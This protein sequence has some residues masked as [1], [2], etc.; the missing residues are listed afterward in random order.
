MVDEKHVYKEY[1]SLPIPTYEEATSS[2]PPSSQSRLGPEEVSDD[3]ERQGLLGRDSSGTHPRR[4]D[5]YHPPTVQSVRSSV[6]SDL[7][8][9]EVTPPSDDEDE[10]EDEALRRDMEE[11]EVLDPEDSETAAQRRARLRRTFS[12]R[13]SSITMTLSSIHFP[14]F[15]S[16]R[17]PF[18]SI[19]FDIISSRLP[20]I[21]DEYRPGWSVLARL[22]GLFVL[23]S[24]IYALLVVEIMPSQYGGLGQ[25]FNSEWVRGFAQS[26]IDLGRI[27]DNLKHIS[28]F[29]H[30]AGSEGSLYLARWIEGLFKDGHMDVY[31]LEDYAVYLNYP[32]EGGRRVAII[33]PPE[34]AWEAKIEEESVYINPTPQQKQTMVF[35]GHSKSGNVK[36]PLI[37]ANY[38]SRE[39]FKL[40]KDHGINVT[41]SV[42]LVRYYGTQG[43]RALKVK[44][45]ELA[46]AIGCIIYSDPEQDGF[47]KGDVWPTGRW[48]P[49]DSVQ[50]GAVS[51]MSWVIGDVLTPGWASRGDVERLSKENN[52]GLVNIP[53]IPLAWRD[54]Q[55]LLSVL[56]GHGEEVPIEWV[57]GIPD[58]DEFWSGDQ[59]SPIVQLK[60]EQDEIEKQPI[61]NVLG[62]IE[63]LETKAKK[64]V[65]GNHRDSWCFGAADP[66]SGTAVMLEVVAILGLLREQGWRPLRTIEFAS[67]DAEEYNL[68]GS[69]EHVEENIEDLRA[70]GVAYLNVDVGV[71]GNK[72]RA[73][74]SPIFKRALLR[75]LDRVGD[76]FK[77]KTLKTIWEESDSR[78]EGLGAGSDYVA[79]QSM[80]GTSSIDFGFDGPGYPYHSCY[81]TFEWMETFGD[82]GFIYHGT[83]AEVWILLILELSQEPIIPFDL[84]TYA[85]AV[86]GYINDMEQYANSKGAP[87][88]PDEHGT[89]FDTTKLVQAATKFKKTAKEFENWQDYW[90]G[91]VYGRAGLESNALA[92]ERVMHNS[93][94]TDFESNLLDLPKSGSD[95]QKHGVPGREQFKHIL[96]APQTWSGYDE[97]Y[98][99]AIRDA[100]D[101]QDWKAAQAQLE[102]AADILANAADK[103]L[104]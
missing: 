29:D 90:Y 41:G 75:V 2:R 11:L 21:P 78:L 97:A 31:G 30:V 9:P 62:V 56:K 17:I 46:G 81:E 87:W 93:R 96:F 12:K 74:A 63:G 45:A 64:I 19:S 80:A 101:A 53:S 49:S 55:R 67:W 59:T 86:T 58:I 33:D 99:P 100:I 8:L 69:T 92:M 36:G 3:A 91:Q 4:R 70:N 27:R 28:S 57:G 104:H 35:H 89:K 6:D 54:A 77:N 5:G 52:P 60:N 48:R 68:I 1:E 15:R 94:M 22:F 40:L 20:Y 13:I 73:S 88:E 42:V 79:F 23:V 76:P 83:L 66:G 84:K 47:G 7:Y 98:F 103:L 10:D 102:K 38:G 85:S 50:R 71:V 25:P 14:S 65:V 44:A 39:D 51:L 72:F 43:D 26:N 16:F 24:A 32:K 82:P 34:L 95:N 37:Y 18:P 61:Y